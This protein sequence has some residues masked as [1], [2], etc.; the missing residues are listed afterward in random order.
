[1]PLKAPGGYIH[2]QE[3][4]CVIVPGRVAALLERHMQLAHLR[5]ALRGSDEELDAVL[6]DL[7]AAA[8]AWRTAVRRPRAVRQATGRAP[9][10]STGE[11]AALL[12][13]TDRAVR[14]AIADRR[15]PAERVDGRWSITREDIAHLEA[16][17]RHRDAS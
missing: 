14:K 15:L 6:V 3:G 12:H 2:G 11:A 16:Q 9:R 5:L 8:E 7:H 10:V 1:V 17:R 4:P 13:I